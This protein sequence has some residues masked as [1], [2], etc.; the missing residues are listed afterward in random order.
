MNLSQLSHWLYVTIAVLAMIAMVGCDGGE[1]SDSHALQTGGTGTAVLSWAPPSMNTDGTPVDLLGLMIY[2]GPSP[3]SMQ[4]V[5]MVSA[6]DTSAV[7]ENLPAGVHFF[8][9]MAVSINGAQS[10]FSNVESKPIG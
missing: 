1:E 9:I 10:A 7:I 2:A 8:V 3:Q 6:I 5:R 4:A